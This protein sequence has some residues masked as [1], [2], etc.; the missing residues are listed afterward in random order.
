MF[1]YDGVPHLGAH[2]DYPP[3]GQTEIHM[4]PIT[5]SDEGKRI[6]HGDEIVGLAINIKDGDAYVNPDPDITDIMMAKLG[7]ADGDEDTFQLQEE[8]IERVTDNAIHLNESL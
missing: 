8:Q 5:E 3:D 6:I 7:W 4:E 2:N 1:S